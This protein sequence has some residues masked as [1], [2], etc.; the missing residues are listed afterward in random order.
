MDKYYVAGQ[1][2]G[3]L[4]LFLIFGWA[5]WY[6][7]KYARPHILK[8]ISWMEKKKMEWTHRMFELQSR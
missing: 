6:V 5:F 3:I 7:R 8:L 2:A 1:I 4:F